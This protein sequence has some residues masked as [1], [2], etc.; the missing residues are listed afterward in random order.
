MHDMNHF[1]KRKRPIQTCRKQNTFLLFLHLAL[2]EK[3]HQRRPSL[4][5]VP[6]PMHNPLHHAIHRTPNHSLHLHALNDHEGLI[7]LDLRAFLNLHSQD[8]TWHG[9]KD[10]VR[11]VFDAEGF[12]GPL[13]H[14]EVQA[15]LGAAL[16]EREAIFVA[17]KGCGEAGVRVEGRQGVGGGGEGA[18]YVGVGGAGDGDGELRGGRLE[19]GYGCGSGLA[20]AIRG[21]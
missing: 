14:G 4:T 3:F 2:L 15:E 13:G 5:Q 7:L 8:F 9:R 11:N 20:F 18:G 21:R 12:L 19:D 16:E 6:F 10:R 17:D 1:A